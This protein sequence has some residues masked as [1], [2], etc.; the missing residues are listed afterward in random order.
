MDDERLPDEAISRACRVDYPPE[1]E[2]DRA[3]SLSAFL[4]LFFICTAI[5]EERLQGT[6]GYA[7]R[8]DA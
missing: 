1:Q 4:I 6:I 8:G 3:L 5:F 7:N 2:V